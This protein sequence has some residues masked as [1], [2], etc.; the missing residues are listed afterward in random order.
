MKRSTTIIAWVAFAALVTLPFWGFITLY[1]STAHQETIK[2]TEKP[3]RIQLTDNDKQRSQLIYA[4][5][6][7]YVNKDSWAMLKF[8]SSDIYGQLQVGRRYNCEVAGWRI[9][10]FSKYKNIIKCEEVK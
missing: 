5:G 7:T 10:F 1:R 9:G 3:P 8:N 4:E 6:A 2:V